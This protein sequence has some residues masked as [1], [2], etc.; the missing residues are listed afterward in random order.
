MRYEARLPILTDNEGLYPYRQ[1]MLRVFQLF[2]VWPRPWTRAGLIRGLRRPSERWDP[3]MP[4]L[5]RRSTLRNSGFRL[6]A[7]KTRPW[8]R[9]RR[10]SG[11]RRGE[12]VV[13]GEARA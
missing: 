10:G 7:G 12:G 2:L 4:R 1:D 13:S 8:F 11:F 5:L 9:E 3:G 6:K